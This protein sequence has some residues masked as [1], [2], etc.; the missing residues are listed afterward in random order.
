MAIKVVSFQDWNIDGVIDG[1]QQPDVKV[2]FYFFSPAFEEYQP[3]KALTNAFPN[4]TCIGASMIGGWSSYGAVEHGITAMSLSADEVEEVYTSL[5]EGVNKNATLAAKAAITELKQKTVNENINPDEY[6]GLIFFDGLCLGELI[7]QEFSLERSFN[8]AFVGGAAADELTFSKTLVGIGDRLSSDGLAVAI[9]KMK[10]PFFFDHYVHYI[11]TDISFTINKVETMRRIA[12][13]IDGEPA[14]AFYA[15]QVGIDDVSKLDSSVFSKNPVGLKFGDSVYARSPRAVVDGRGLQ[16]YCYIEAGNKVHLLKQGEIISHA[17]QT[18]TSAAQFLPGIQGCLLFNC[19]LRYLE[20]K[21]LNKLDTFNDVFNKYPMIGFNTYGE[22]LF[23]HHNQTLTAVFFGNPIREDSTDPYKAKRLFHYI[24]GKLKTLV[25]DIISRNEI[26]NITI[27][28]FKDRMD[29]DFAS[30]D[31]KTVDSRQGDEL[32]AKYAAATKRLDAMVELSNV[33]KKDIEGMIIVCQNNVEETGKYVFNIVDDIRAQNRRLVELREQA[34]T[35]SRTKSNFLASM[36]HEIRTPMN[37][38]IGMAELLLRGELSNESRGYV[39][40]IKHASANLLSIINDLLDFSKIEAGKLEIIPTRYLLASLIND[41]VSIIRMRIAEKPIRFYTNID[42]NIPNSLIGDEVRLRQ[43][44]LNLLTNAVKYTEKGQIGIIITQEKRKCDAASPKVW[45]KITVNDTG[46]GIKP[47]DQKR[48]FEDFVQ[49]D[50][51][52]NRTIEGTGL[53]LSIVRK[54]CKA[55]GGNITLQ[56]EYG[57]GSSFTVLIPQGVDLPEPFAAVEEPEGKKV[58]VY[59]RRNSYTQSLCWSLENMK[60]PYALV[61][62]P[63]SFAEALSREAWF[64]IFSSYGMYTTVKPILDRPDAFFYGGKKPSL[65]LMVELGNEA[66]IPKVRFMSVPVQAL[67]I[68][69]VLNGQADRHDY[70]ESTGTIQYTYPDARLLIVDDISTN[71]K[72]AQGLLSPYKAT[73]D[74]CLSGVEAVELVKQKCYD[75]VFMDH[76]MPDMD[77]IEAMAI[78]RE[79]EKEL[80]N[81][82]LVR[83]AIPIVAL[84]ANAVSGMRELFIEQGFSD[85]LAKPI[86]ISKLDEMLERWIPEEKRSRNRIGDIGNAVDKSPSDTSLPFIPGVDTAKGIVNTGGTLAGYQKVLSMFRKDAEERLLLLQTIPRTEALPTFI[87]QVHALKSAS[88][89]LGAGK[90]SE[91]AAKLECAG[92]S[93]DLVFIEKNLCLFTERL[94]ELV[95]NIATVLDISDAWGDAP[96]DESKE[97]GTPV[98]ISAY[99]PVLC[100]LS[101]ALKAKDASEIDRIM[102]DLNQK[103]LDQKTRETLEK[104]SDDVLVAEFGNALKAIDELVATKKQGD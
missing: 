11:P 37:A 88:A 100:E 18:L 97:A 28:Q 90:V 72:V 27:S 2:V 13:E 20:L 104:V 54:L 46:Y 41:V 31:W 89:S 68:A 12:W 95:K 55:M 26:M 91:L 22:E 52:K 6:L 102:D 76:M 48:L 34:E 58:L 94:S 75:I 40:D 67:S 92:L 14:A 49:V 84:T 71:L 45:L 44:L 8:M 66:Y 87:T 32:L 1:I 17:E 38:I 3:Q 43:I 25:F 35:A 59:E 9:L 39:Q 86:D 63:D 24:D 30:V 80:L 85:F 103:P 62:D 73:V 42:C 10:I 21:E 4:A 69:N 77:G 61:V 51:K 7:M 93:E 5:H 81:E 78:I 50:T 23:T 74:T 82:G 64:F 53:G 56:S 57:K 98:D 83:D 19:V 99:L 70:F 47:E 36:S 15:R 79:W 96:T 29:D 65:A 33:S 101:E 60:V 16:F